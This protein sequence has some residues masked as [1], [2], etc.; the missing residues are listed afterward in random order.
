MKLYVVQSVHNDLYAFYG[1]TDVPRC[2]SCGNLINKWNSAYLQVDVPPSVRMDISMTYDGVT[3]VTAAF[4]KIATG[5]GLRGL[6]FHHLRP[7]FSALT[8]ARRVRFDAVSRRTRFENQ[9]GRCGQYEA[10]AGATP[11]FLCS[12]VDVGRDEFVWTD[13]EFGSGDEKQIGRAHV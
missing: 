10:V 11:A 12:P 3:I 1:R 8:S 4:E 13:V 9:C 2:P 6:Q 5:N 7:E